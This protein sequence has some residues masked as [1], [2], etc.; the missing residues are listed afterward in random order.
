MEARRIILIH[1]HEIAL[2]GG[3]RKYFEKRLQRNLGGV[4]E[5]FELGKIIPVA[6]RLIIPLKESLNYK[7]CGEIANVARMVPG[8]ARVSCG[9]R[10]ARKL[11][12]INKVAI[13]AL[14]EAPQ[15]ETFKVKARR[16][17]TDF[18]YDSMK[19]N[20][21]VG[22]ALCD[23]FPEKGVK[24]KGQDATVHV[25][26]V[27]GSCYIYVY[28]VPGIGGLPVGTAGKLV[29]MLS[30]GI[31]SPVALWRMARRGAICIGVH[32]L[33]TPVTSDK[34]EYLVDD[35]AHVLEKTGCI[36]KVYIVKLGEYQKKIA[37][38]CDERVRIILYRRLMYK[39]AEEIA[40][41]EGAYGLVTGE[42]LG[43]VASQTLEN[44]LATTAAVEIPVYR[45]LVGTDKI[46]I[47]NDAEN[48]GTLKISEIQAPD[49]CTLFM[50]RHP[51]IH[52]KL[53]KVEAEEASF[54]ENDWISELVNSATVKK[55]VNFS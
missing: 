3:N 31:D 24:M 51:E 30:S 26:V 22:S 8:V 40:H 5:C 9:F 18:K 12:V 25:D 27:Q 17:H 4:L 7:A 43:Q 54:P 53:E 10:C 39:I 49:C 21:L 2:K 46:E 23:R 16:S 33:G 41:R 52:A 11:E 48:L 6:G 45:P 42:S 34:S 20:K 50:P 15:F 35:I 38:E 1:Y 29:C 14:S 47:I 36:D 13:A 28:S 19:L 55:Y 32:F 37:L 44:L